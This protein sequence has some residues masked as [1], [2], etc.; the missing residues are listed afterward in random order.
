MPP[1]MPPSKDDLVALGR[2]EVGLGHGLAARRSGAS[3][4]CARSGGAPVDQIEQAVFQAAVELVDDRE[5]LA[6]L[7]AHVE[8][9][10][11]AHGRAEHDAAA[12]RRVRLD[13][14]A[15]ERDHDR[16]VALELEPED[17]GVGGVDQA[18]ADALA[19][20]HREILRHAAVDVT[21]LPTRPLWRLSMTLPKSSLIWASGNRRQSSSTQ[22]TSRSTRIGSG[23]ST[24]SGPYSP[25]PTC[26]KLRWCG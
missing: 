6:R 10:I 8:D 25:R 5:A 24:I 21:V 26:S 9:Q 19:G 12:L 7:A 22:V 4:G 11:G 20:A 23:S 15:V 17:A 3:G 18:Q 13:R 2:G 16:P 14:L 1:I